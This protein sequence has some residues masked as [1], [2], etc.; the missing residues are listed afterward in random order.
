MSPFRSKKSPAFVGGDASARAERGAPK[1]NKTRSRLKAPIARKRPIIPPLSM[2]FES[3]GRARKN[4]VVL[5]RPTRRLSPH[6]RRTS[7]LLFE[8]FDEF[9]DPFLSFFR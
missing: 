6:F 7:T 8:I 3:N 1:T 2:G 5:R 9:P 4:P